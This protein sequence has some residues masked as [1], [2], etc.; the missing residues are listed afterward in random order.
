M[1]EINV[2][3]IEEVKIHDTALGIRREVTID[4][5]KHYIGLGKYYID[6]VGVDGYKVV[7]YDQDDFKI[8]A[9]VL[10]ETDKDPEK[11]VTPGAFK[12]RSLAGGDGQ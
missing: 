5:V 6:D 4:E 7:V 3:E 9:T 8:L 10:T 1:N 2:N 11:I 12:S